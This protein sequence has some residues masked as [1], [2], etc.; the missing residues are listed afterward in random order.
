MS[1]FIKNNESKM[2]LNNWEANNKYSAF[3]ETGTIISR[4][5]FTYLL[6]QE[7]L[8]NINDQREEKSANNFTSL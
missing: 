3:E 7:I 8:G 2:I 1:F 5:K 4:I 6:I